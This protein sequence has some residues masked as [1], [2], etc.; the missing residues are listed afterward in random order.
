MLNTIAAFNVLLRQ[1]MSGYEHRFKNIPNGF[2][3]IAFRP[4][5]N[6]VSYV[7]VSKL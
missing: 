3:M 4:S 6:A 7:Q 5:E 1:I 2:F